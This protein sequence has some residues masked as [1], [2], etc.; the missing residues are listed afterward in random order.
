MSVSELVCRAIKQKPENKRASR[1]AGKPLD[2]STVTRMGL[3]ECVFGMSPKAQEAILLEASKG[4]RYSD[5]QAY[6]FKTAIAK[7]FGVEIENVITASGSSPIIDAISNIFLDEGDELLTC[8]PTFQAFT[9]ATYT[10]MAIPVMLDLTEDAEFDLDAMLKAINEKTKIIV[11]CNPN[12]PTGTCLTKTAIANFLDKV[13]ENIVV[14]MDEA[15]IEF[16]EASDCGSMVE[17]M[18]S[19]PEKP[20]IILRT[21]SKYY[22][23]AGIRAGYALAQPEVIDELMKSSGIWNLSGVAQI[24]GIEALNDKEHGKYVLEENA[25]GRKYLM[26]ELK[27]LGLRV[28]DSQTNFVYFN[29]HR[30]SQELHAQLLELGVHT[31]AGHMYNRVTVS[32]MEDC[33]FFIAKMK[34]I[35]GK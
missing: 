34:E 24:A 20:I 18:K 28:Y 25:K 4:N 7:N 33:E 15:Y 22:G 30:P 19:H 13:P 16:V 29:A 35:L 31:G 6:D 2:F 14:V 11:I 21:F 3:N 12:N 8:H 5:F 32:T 23:L 17:Y 10:N 9:D 1:K 26:K 27:D